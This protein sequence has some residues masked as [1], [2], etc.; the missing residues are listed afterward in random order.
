M[1]C[2]RPQWPG[3]ILAQSAL[4]PLVAHDRTTGMNLAQRKQEIEEKLARCRRLQAD[5]S[6]GPTAVHLRELEA[7]LQAQLRVLDQ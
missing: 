1:I 2:F 7:E 6:E 3:L 5:Y 4:E